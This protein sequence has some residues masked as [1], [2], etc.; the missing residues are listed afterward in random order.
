MCA[1]YAGDAGSVA[2][3]QTYL[4]APLNAGHDAPKE[5]VLT[6]AEAD[7]RY[8]IGPL[9]LRVER[10]DRRNP[11]TYEGETWFPVE[12]V[13]LRADGVEVRRRAVLV[14]AARL[15]V[16]PQDRTTARPA[17]SRATGTRKGEQ[18]T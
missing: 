6:L 13:Q 14:K 1:G 2:C 4:M 10:V 15:V 3:C 8:G 11:A 5:H 17:S 16:P 12:G 7:Y 18:D 9:R